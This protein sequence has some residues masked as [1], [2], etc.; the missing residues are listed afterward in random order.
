LTTYSALDSGD[1]ASRYQRF[2][3]WAP[4]PASALCST[5][6]V[7]RSLGPATA[8][9]STLRRP[10]QAA[11]LPP[12]LLS[13]DHFHPTPVAPTAH[14]TPPFVFSSYTTLRYGWRRPKSR[15]VSNPDLLFDLLFH[16]RL[17]IAACFYFPFIF[18]Y[19]TRLALLFLWLLLFHFRLAACFHATRLA[20]LSPAYL[21]RTH[22]RCLFCIIGP[23][24]TPP[25]S[26]TLRARPR[27]VLLCI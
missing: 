15:F 13:P 22:H 8:W 9:A 6:A 12:S 2:T 4:T 11:E 24:R 1:L 19:A 23:S 27:L 25:V 16:F 17:S 18:M 7:A 10:N 26:N 14:P 3:T 5:W 21:R 20:R